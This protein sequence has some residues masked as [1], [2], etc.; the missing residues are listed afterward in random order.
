MNDSSHR[1][2]GTETPNEENKMTNE[3]IIRLNN[4]YE[5]QVNDCVEETVNSFAKL[6]DFLDA[7][8]FNTLSIKFETVNNETIAKKQVKTF[9]R[10][11]NKLAKA[12]NMEVAFI[13]NQV[14]DGYEFPNHFV[15]VLV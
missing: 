10:R 11:I 8:E 4:S 3:I 14:I 13:K 5:V 12:L 15:S 9:T 2:G 6:I 7:Y 1:L